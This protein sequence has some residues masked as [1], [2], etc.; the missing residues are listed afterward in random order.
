MLDSH[1]PIGWEATL[2]LTKL[3]FSASHNHAVTSSG[4]PLQEWRIG[5]AKARLHALLGWRPQ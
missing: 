3:R 4:N 2:W 5:I 1:R